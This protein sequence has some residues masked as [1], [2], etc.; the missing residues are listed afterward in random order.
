MESRRSCDRHHDD[1]ED[2]C[3][4]KGGK[5]ARGT[6]GEVARGQ[7][8]G[9]TAGGCDGGAEL[10]WEEPCSR[11]KVEEK[12]SSWRRPPCVPQPRSQDTDAKEKPLAAMRM[13]LQKRRGS[14][15]GAAAPRQVPQHPQEP[16]AK[17]PNMT[18]A[19]KRSWASVVRGTH[20]DLRTSLKGPPQERDVREKTTGREEKR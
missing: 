7:D 14:T 6:A 1:L 12:T 3:S 19:P 16:G 4:R 18:A 17:G 10:A 5:G 2:S 13:V 8:R 9:R 20:Q 11:G 15:P